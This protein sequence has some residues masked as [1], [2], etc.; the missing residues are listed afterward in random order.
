MKYTVREGRHYQAIV[1]L[2]FWQQLVPNEEIADR[3]RQVGFTEVDVS[4]SGRQRLA[5]GLWPKPDASADLPDEIDPNS[6]R[7]IEV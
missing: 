6:I 7:E 4:G 3:F 1:L 5:Q 2:G